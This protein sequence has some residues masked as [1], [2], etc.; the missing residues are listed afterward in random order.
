MKVLKLA[1]RHF[2]QCLFSKDFVFQQNSRENVLSQKPKD[3]VDYL[4]QHVIS[5]ERAKK[6]MAIAYRNRIRRKQL[7]AELQK[8]I[9]PK[10]ILMIGSTGSGKTELARRIA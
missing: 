2:S 6:V 7:A 10:N 9:I 8:E 3:I 5:Q 1:R 4:D